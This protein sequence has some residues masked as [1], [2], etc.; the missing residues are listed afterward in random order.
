[1]VTSNRGDL[2]PC[3]KCKKD[4][5]PDF[6]WCPY[7]GKKQIAQR[8]KGKTH[9]NG[10]GTV[11]KRDGDKT[12]T[13]EY[14]AGWSQDDNGKL[15]RTRRAKR[16]FKTAKE[17]QAFLNNLRMTPEEVKETTAA[18]KTVAQM[19]D[20]YYNTAMQK[21]SKTKQDAYRIAY[22]K[23][24]QPAIGDKPIILVDR[25]MLDKI[26]KPLT[27]YPAKDVRDL[28]SLLFQRA[29]G[30]GI[31]QVNPTKFVTMP[32]L[33]SEEI[34]PWLPSEIELLWEEWGANNRI[35]GCCLLMIYSGMMPGELFR[36]KKD[37]ITW[38]E[39]KIVGCGMKTKKRKELP[40]VFPD[41]IS[42]VLHDLCETTVSREGYVV[43]MNRDYFYRDFKDMKKKLG[44]REEV[45]P[46]SSR[47]ST[48]T[49]L[50]LMGVS[51][52][53]IIDIMRHKNYS[54]TL[55]HYIKIPTKDLVGSLNLLD[56]AKAN[57]ENNP[58]VSAQ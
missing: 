8:Q 58:P 12:W 37:M 10:I 46:Y 52:G 51:P 56:P 43:G 19:Y 34:V 39:N 21:L 25:D 57:R 11:F 40:I 38:E 7:C 5:Q 17:A 54:V 3:I 48:G 44:I 9:G 1:M 29:M 42:P 50:E 35:A 16:G 22:T 55:E 28:M 36:L 30:D 49:E 14:T 23:R 27:Y 32:D 31:M 53:V 20:S 26:I 45:T 33:N 4:L 47:H 15:K 24:I 13:A 18:A 41:F 2:M 6:I